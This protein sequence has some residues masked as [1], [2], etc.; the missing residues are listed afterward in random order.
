MLRIK[1]VNLKP[2][3]YDAIIIRKIGKDDLL[4]EL[5]LE[6]EPEESWR[7]IFEEVLKTLFKQTQPLKTNKMGG[8]APP[9]PFEVTYP[10]SIE[11]ECETVKLITDQ[12]NIRSDIILVMRL[13]KTVNERVDL[14]NNKME[15]KAEAEGKQTEKEKEMIRSIRESLKENPPHL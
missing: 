9:S 8:I 1:K 10:V 12:K 11:E 2:I 6:E 13:V 14:E 7:K 15:Q 3:N 5:P 4:L